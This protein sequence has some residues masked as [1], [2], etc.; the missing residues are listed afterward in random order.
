MINLEPLDYYTI[1]AVLL[2]CLG[3]FGLMIRRNI[4]VLMMCIE[5]MLNAVNL[6]FVA[7]AIY[8]GQIQ[9]LVFTIF[10]MVLAAAEVTIGLALII[11]IYRHYQLVDSKQLT[12][13]KG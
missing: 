8:T 9:G 13:L 1:L 3:L 10:I 2:F 6:L 7:T 4:I 5:L 11:C 12:R